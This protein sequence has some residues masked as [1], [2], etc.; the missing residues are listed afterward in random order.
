MRIREKWRGWESEK[1]VEW[2]RGV[3]YWQSK[4]PSDKI[5]RHDRRGTIYRNVGQLTLKVN[6]KH[7]T[8]KERGVQEWLSLHLRCLKAVGD[9]SIPTTPSRAKL[10]SSSSQLA[11][12]RNHSW[13]FLPNIHL[14]ETCRISSMPRAPTARRWQQPC[15]PTKALL[16]HMLARTG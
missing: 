13:Q 10:M 7:F 6:L 5:I 16:G 15:Y 2:P 12:F 8:R 4:C 1:D 9:Y 3:F 11:T 14:A